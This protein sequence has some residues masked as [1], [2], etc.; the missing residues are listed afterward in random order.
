MTAAA[1]F[2][3][4]INYFFDDNVPQVIY[5]G[6]SGYNNTTRYLERDRKKYIIRIYET[7]QEESKVKVEHE[8]L[9]KLAEDPERPFQIPIPVCKE[10]NSLVRL[11]SNKIGC[12]YHYIEGDNPVF[13]RADVLFS[14]GQSTGYLLHALEK[15]KLNQP[16]VYRPY[17]EIEYAHPNCPIEKVEAWCSQPPDY[18][19]RYI[20]ELSWVS[21]EL[22][23]FQ[24]FTPQ[25]KRLPH[26]MI[27]GDLNESN[28]L[29]GA[30]NKIN[31]ILDFEFA[32]WDLRIMEV[33]VC[34]SEIM[35]EEPNEN[36]YLDKIKHFFDGL[37][38]TGTFTNPE[39]EALPVLVLLRRLDVFLH[40]LGRYQDGLDDASVLEEQ[41]IKVAT[42]ENWLTSRAE[43]V[44]R[45][46]R[47]AE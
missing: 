26:Q 24:R 36:I 25:L 43:K 18:F 29:V 2:D 3:Y 47:R 11:P 41:I 35:S 8:L 40:F 46:L 39:L 23:D 22:V 31:A 20:K 5:E 17:Y 6:K 45:L 38:N 33:A 21:S 7:H 42:Y 1:E 27:H 19:K 15:I 10:G 12:L 32:T 13:D 30:D 4:L 44:V 9:L 16:L 37:G 28:V 34:I 14:F